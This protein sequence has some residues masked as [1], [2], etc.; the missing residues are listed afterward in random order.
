MKWLILGRIFKYQAFYIEFL[1]D[2]LAFLV[3]IKLDGNFF[4]YFYP[5]YV[6][7]TLMYPI[8]TIKG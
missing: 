6:Q 5:F 3:T 2:Q 8:A 1:K 4:F 7:F